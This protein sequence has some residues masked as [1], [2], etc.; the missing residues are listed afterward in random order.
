MAS[1]SPLP[2]S[3]DPLPDESLPGYLLRLAHRLGLAPIRVMQLTGLTTSQDG[4]QPARRNL[5]IHLDQAATRTVLRPHHQTH[6]N[7]NRGTMHEQHVRPVF[8]GGTQIRLEGPQIFRTGDPIGFSPERDGIKCRE[9]R[10]AT[11]L[12]LRS[13]PSRG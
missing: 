12:N 9:S 11:L 2:R 7:R 4:H 10:K 13:K 3:L 8:V 6:R 1:L 5:M